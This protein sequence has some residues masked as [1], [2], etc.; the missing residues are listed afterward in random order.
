MSIIG[1]FCYIFVRIDQKVKDN[2]VYIVLINKYLLGVCYVFRNVYKFEGYS[3]EE[4]RYN[5]CFYR[6]FR[7]V[8]MIGN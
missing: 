6:V 7:L 1:E 2:K 3:N 4:R 5:Y 8:W